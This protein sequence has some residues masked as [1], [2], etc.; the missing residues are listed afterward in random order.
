MQL[1]QIP[2]IESLRRMKALFIR[3]ENAGVQGLGA[4]W[5]MYRPAWCAGCR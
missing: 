3:V 1:G 4:V 2:K 5:A